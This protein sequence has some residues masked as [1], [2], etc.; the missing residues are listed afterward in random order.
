MSVTYARTSKSYSLLPLLDEYSRSDSK[1]RS[2]RSENR[3]A[4]NEP[5]YFFI[6]EA[7]F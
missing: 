5:A 7:P 1:P 2:S 6:Q 4:G 3:E